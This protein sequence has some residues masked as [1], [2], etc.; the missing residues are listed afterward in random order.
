MG[1]AVLE[2]RSSR[3]MKIRIRFAVA[4]LATAGTPSAQTAQQIGAGRASYGTMCAG[5]HA[6]DLGGAE[7]PQLGGGNFRAA[8]GTR[9]AR[10]LV[11]FIQTN[12]PPGSAGLSEADASN[13]AA[14]ILAS[15]GAAAG[16]Q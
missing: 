9:T 5:C 14:F 15:N 1:L 12:M 6:P 2:I 7:A 13:L 11:M 8:W 10:E 4:A 16:A 3:P